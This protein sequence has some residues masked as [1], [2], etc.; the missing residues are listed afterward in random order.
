M[1]LS[2]KDERLPAGRSSHRNFAYMYDIMV[3]FSG[4]EKMYWI[5]QKI[6]GRKR[7][8]LV[9]PS[10]KIRQGGK[11]YAWDGQTY[12]R[13]DGHFQS[14]SGQL[15]VT[16]SPLPVIWSYEALQL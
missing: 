12:G 3:S 15:P 7:P 10:H 9:D 16:S 1:K 4:T 8:E 14:T 11:G 2:L 5:L 13:T 6:A